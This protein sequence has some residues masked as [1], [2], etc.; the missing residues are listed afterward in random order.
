MYLWHK[1]PEPLPLRIEFSAM[2]AL[3][4][5]HIVMPALALPEIVLPCVCMCV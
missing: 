4:P 5:V 1:M 3:A 2:R